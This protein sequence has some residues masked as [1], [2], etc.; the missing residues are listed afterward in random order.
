MKTI[1]ELGLDLAY[2]RTALQDAG[3]RNTPIDE[4]ER[5]KAS[6]EL[7]RLGRAFCLAEA[8]LRKALQE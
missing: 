7:E 5:M 3:M 8:L 2:A 4:V 6:L 1:E